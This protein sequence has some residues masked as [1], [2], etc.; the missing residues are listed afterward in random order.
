[1]YLKDESSSWHKL[2]NKRGRMIKM[3]TD[4]FHKMEIQKEKTCY[5]LILTFGVVKSAGMMTV[6]S[7][8]MLDSLKAS[9]HFLK[10]F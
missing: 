4:L 10:I 7:L 1:M 3:K 5:L 6:R 8:E 2:E 9:V